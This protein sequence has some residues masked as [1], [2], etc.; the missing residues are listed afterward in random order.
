MPASPRLFRALPANP[1]AKVQLFFDSSKYFLL[2]YVKRKIFFIFNFINI[3][4]L[5]ISRIIATF[6]VG[7]LWD[8][9]V[10]SSGVPSR[11]EKTCYPHGQHVLMFNQKSNTM[12]NNFTSLLC[13][14]DSNPR[15]FRRT[16]ILTVCPIYPDLRLPLVSHK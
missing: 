7:L 8:T 2:I 3:I 9:L 15:R 1:T 4:Y 12:K 6:A 13:E 10:G 14:R 5:D 16:S 11:H